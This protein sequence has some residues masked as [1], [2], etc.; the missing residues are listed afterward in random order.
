MVGRRKRS[1]LVVDLSKG[2]VRLYAALV[3]TAGEYPLAIKRFPGLDGGEALNLIWYFAR[4]FKCLVCRLISRSW[5][6]IYPEV[7]FGTTV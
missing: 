3:Y 2:V 4:M 5:L 6:I 7:T 1:T